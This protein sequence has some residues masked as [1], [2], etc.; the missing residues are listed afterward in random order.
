[1]LAFA[2][3]ASTL[4]EL[5]IGVS[6]FS[7]GIW[8]A[9]HYFNPT[10]VDYEVERGSELSRW[11]Y[12]TRAINKVMKHGRPFRGE[13]AGFHDLFVPI[14]VGE[15]V[16]AVLVVGPFAVAYPTSAEITDRWRRI[17]HARPSLADP[18]FSGYLSTTLGTLTLDV[19]LVGAFEKLLVCYARA[20]ASETRHLSKLGK[21]THV[22]ATKVLRARASEKMWE[23]ARSMIDERT[24]RV[25]ATPIRRG[26]LAELG[27]QRPPEH[28]VVGLVRGLSHEVDPID[29]ALRR[30]AFQRA[31]TELARKRGDVACG[32]V[33]DHGIALLAAPAK[34]AA[35]A[36]TPLL[37]LTERAGHLARR[38]G[39]TLHAGIAPATG[40]S[41]LAERYRAA[42][43]AAEKA[44]SRAEPVALAEDRPASPPHLLAELRDRL[45]DGGEGHPGLLAA[46]FEQYIEAVLVHTGYQ[47]DATRAHLEAGL[48]RVASPLLSSGQLDRRAYVDLRV[49]IDGAPRG[50]GTVAALLAQYRRVA[51]DL[52]RAVHNP[53]PARQTRSTERALQFMREHLAD[54]LTLAQVARVAAFAPGHFSKLLKREQGLTFERY[55]QSLRLERAKHMLTSTALHVESVAQRS[56]F[57]S[58]THFQQVFRRKVGQTPIAY[59]RHTKE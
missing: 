21:E 29:E 7:D 30:H 11:D 39:F 12:N 44:L 51:A 19:G 20:L 18:S 16:D 24:T 53:T 56:G 8:R 58:R 52:E 14:L 50:G 36:R 37:D 2:Q 49:P 6:I 46:R 42:L 27:M 25:W 15:E 26:P 13:H 59:R 10:V 1:M 5:S 57:R 55:L 40:V 43:A 41:S 3:S 4:Q 22:L 31:A 9:I 38:F 28:A 47:L 32:Q 45:A 54:P 33:G 35:R 48:E 17:A 23:S 34:G